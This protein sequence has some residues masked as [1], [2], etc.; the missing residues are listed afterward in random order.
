M[1]VAKENAE[2]RDEWTHMSLGPD[3][4]EVLL[5]AKSGVEWAWAAIYRDL[6]GPVT[7][8]FTSHGIADSEDLTSEVFLHVARDVKRFEGDEKAFRSW[9]FVIAHRRLV[10]TWRSV[11]RRPKTLSLTGL[12]GEQEGGNVEEEALSRLVTDE[13]LRAFERLTDDQ[14]AVLAL[15]IVGG[16]TL[17]ETAGVLRR[18]VGAVKALQHRGIA[19]LR[20]VMRRAE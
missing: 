16:L 3:F 17:E 2:R 9:V 14:R 4:D 12:V 20:E 5:A 6:A 8:Y 11:G 13:I 19:S 18:R 7:G 15:R 1:L 10:D